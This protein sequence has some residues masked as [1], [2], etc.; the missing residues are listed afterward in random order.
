MTPSGPSQ[1][2]QLAALRRITRWYGE[3]FAA[4]MEMARKSQEHG[5]QMVIWAT[6]LMGAGLLALPAFLTATCGPRRISLVLP[7]S[8]W[9]AGVIVAL[10]ARV[11]GGLR[12]DAEDTYHARK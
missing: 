6:G 7:A 2:V 11:L 12:R 5:D 1:S 4:G 3:A 9:A 8:P 10:L